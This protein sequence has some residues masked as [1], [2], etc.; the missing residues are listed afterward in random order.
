MRAYASAG[1]SIRT[2]M[3]AAEYRRVKPRHYWCPIYLDVGWQENGQHS[4][5]GSA[6]EAYVS[7]SAL[8]LFEAILAHMGIAFLFALVQFLQAFPSDVFKRIRIGDPVRLCERRRKVLVEAE[9][10][11]RSL[12]HCP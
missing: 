12:E 4:C 9:Y 2:R 6:P 11:V 1:R 7:F 10:D 3:K 5:I 8:S